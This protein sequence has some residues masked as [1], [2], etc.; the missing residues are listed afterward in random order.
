MLK[1]LLDET[2]AN[3]TNHKIRESID[4]ILVKQPRLNDDIEDLL[5]QQLQVKDILGHLTYI[6]DHADLKLKTTLIKVKQ[7]PEYMELKTLKARD[8]RA[9]ME[10]YPIR[11][12][13]LQ[14]RYDKHLLEDYEV[15]LDYVIK[16]KLSS[17]SS[18][19]DVEV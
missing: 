5:I 10:A 17:Y 15:Y 2:R 18:G 12:Y 4:D 7:S 16:Y 3:I 1:D 6:I 19:D 11:E 9:T 8:E 14:L 13:F